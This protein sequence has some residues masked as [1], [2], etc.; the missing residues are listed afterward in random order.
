MMGDPEVSRVTPSPDLEGVES[1]TDETLLRRFRGGTADAATLLYFRYADQLHTLA[2]ARLSA[3]LAPRVGAEDIVQSV[4]RTFFR[5]AA[6]GQFEVPDGEDLWKLFLVIALNKIRSA[7]S[8][9]RA[10][11]R[12]VTRTPQ[13][14]AEANPVDISGPDDEN[15]LTVLRLV[16]DE[17]LAEL[18]ESARPIV[19]LRVEGH[20]VAEIAHRVRRSRRSVERILREFRERLE[21]VISAE[22]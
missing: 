19:E 22:G 9:H 5:R 11:R 16:I 6:L 13:G 1:F 4:F 3:D 14:P 17:V 15:A 2:A 7:G 18:P 20:E 12:S 10:A 8:Y 21:A